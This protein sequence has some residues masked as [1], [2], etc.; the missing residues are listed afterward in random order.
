MS[1]ISGL[2]HL[3]VGARRAFAV[4]YRVDHFSAAV[5]AI[6]PSKVAGIAGLAGFRIDDDDSV[7]QL[8]PAQFLYKLCEWRLPDSRYHVVALNGVLGV[9]DG[10]QRIVDLVHLDSVQQ[11][12]TAL[13]GANRIRL[14]APEELHSF[15]LGVLVFE[16]KGCHLAL[17]ATIEQVDSVCA[18]SPGCTGSVNGGLSRHNNCS[19]SRHLLQSPCLVGGYK[20]QGV[21][22]ALLVLAGNVHALHRSESDTE[23]KEVELRLQLLQS[24]RRLDCRACPELNTHAADHLRLAQAVGGAKLILGYAIGVQPTRKFVPF[25]DDGVRSVPAKFGGAAKRCRSAADTCNLNVA[26]P[27]RCC[28]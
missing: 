5:G 14:P 20:L 17:A 7:A 21:Q 13:I 16:V 12:T 23:E 1:G 26:R 11:Q 10:L 3:Q 19:R 15:M 8:D 28:E 22:H 6:A 4:R 9:V 2:R 18:E 25:D 27:S 24:V